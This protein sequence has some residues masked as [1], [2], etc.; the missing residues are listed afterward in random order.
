[1]MI[2]KLL[3]IGSIGTAEVLVAEVTET[4]VDLVVTASVSL[5]YLNN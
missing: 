4:V 2:V 1:M 3:L 5:N